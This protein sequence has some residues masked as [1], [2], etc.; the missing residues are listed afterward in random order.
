MCRALCE[1][2]WLMG[3]WKDMENMAKRAVACTLGPLLVQGGFTA[4]QVSQS[5]RMHAGWFQ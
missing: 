2:L 1:A 5:I 3:M 4:V